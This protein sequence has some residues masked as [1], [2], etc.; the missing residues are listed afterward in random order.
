MSYFRE[1]IDALAGYQ[2]GEQPQAGKFIKLNTN[3]NPYRASTAVDRAVGAVMERGLSRYPDRDG[4]TRFECGA[5]ELLG[6][7][8]D[9]ILCG[10][11][12]D[13][14]L[15][16]VTRAF[17]GEWSSGCGCRIPV[18]CLYKT[19]AEIQGAASEEVAFRSG[20]V[21]GRIIRVRPKDGLAFGLS[22][23]PEQSFRERLIAPQE[24]LELAERLPCPVLV[25]EAYAEFAETNCVSNWCTRKA[26][27]FWFRDH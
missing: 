5:A 12:S 11:G 2:P 4:R 1:Q 17:V 19:L 18:T 6:V 3:E 25:D 20:L 10:N 13:D 24:V 7:E 8:P 9:W 26:T 15:T 27:R 16:M 14:I 23:E 22:S 21:V